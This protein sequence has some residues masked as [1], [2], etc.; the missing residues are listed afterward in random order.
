MGKHD[1]QLLLARLHLCPSS[2]RVTDVVE[3][4]DGESARHG[5][6]VLPPSARE[7]GVEGEDGQA[8]LQ[9]RLLRLELLF[10]HHSAGHHFACVRY[11]GTHHPHYG[12]I[13]CRVKHFG[14]ALAHHPT[15]Y[16]VTYSEFHVVDL[17][18]YDFDL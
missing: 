7:G 13:Q 10:L 12:R 15:A 11:L 8:L 4:V 1:A 5:I 2:A 16:I 3:V 14:G 9:F 6:V 18:F 17:R